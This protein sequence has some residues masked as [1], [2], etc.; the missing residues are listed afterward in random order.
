MPLL[1]EIRRAHQPKSACKQGARKS[2]ME[3]KS[4]VRNSPHGSET[5][6]RA[7]VHSSLAVINKSGLVTNILFLEWIETLNGNSWSTH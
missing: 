3:L 4:R 7:G 5:L 6:E 1:A 2:H